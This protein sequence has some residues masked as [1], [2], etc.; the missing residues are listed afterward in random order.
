VIVV[1]LAMAFLKERP[2]RSFFAWAPLA[3]LAGVAISF[4][5]FDFRFTSEIS[6][7][8]QGSL[9]A[10]AAAAIWAAATVIGKGVVSKLSPTFVTYCRFVFGLLTSAVL[11]AISGGFGSISL[12]FADPELMRSF[13]YIAL[14]PGLLALLLYYQGMLRTPATTTTFME[15]LFPV[16]AIVV[17]TYFLDAPLLAMQMAAAL[18]LLF[19]VTQISLAN[20]GRD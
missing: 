15:L 6:T 20:R 4:P 2:A 9:Y 3:L 12:P 1:L 16:S 10:F 7:S 8:S 5:T 11:L 17:N 14:V 13:L 19:A 18:V